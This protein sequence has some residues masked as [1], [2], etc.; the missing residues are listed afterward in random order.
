MQVVCEATQASDVKTRIAAYECLVKIASLYYSKLA[1]WMQNIF[2]VC[3]P[4]NSMMLVLTS[5][6][7]ITLEAIRKDEEGV[8]LQA[9]EYWS[10][11]CDV[12][13]DILME[14]DEVSYA[15]V[16]PLLCFFYPLFPATSFPRDRAH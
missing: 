15:C 10:T 8:A 1:A 3:F 4:S 6:V 12:E 2:N 11:I 7:Q 9:V 5:F 14:T 16:V 13:I